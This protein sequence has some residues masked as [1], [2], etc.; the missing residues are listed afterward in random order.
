MVWCG[1]GYLNGTSDIFQ[2]NDPMDKDGN[3]LYD[4]G[5]DASR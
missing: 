5:I 3:L 2:L 4:C 1:S